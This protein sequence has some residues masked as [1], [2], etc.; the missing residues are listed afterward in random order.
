M[1]YK[2]KVGGQRGDPHKDK[3]LAANVAVNIQLVLGGEGNLGGD[4][5]DGGDD[6]GDGEDEAS[7]EADE[8]RAQ[9]EPAR[10]EDQRG[11]EQQDAVE[12]GAGHE[13]G[14]HD[15]RADAQ[16]RQ[17]GDDLGGQGDAGA[18]Q[19]LAD[20]DLDGVEPEEG[21]RRGA[22]RDASI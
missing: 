19:E 10:L 17:D 9:A 2:G 15:L 6:G 13:E 8:G 5:D 14:V 22:E 3:H 1:Q 11:Q 20:E 12:D 4:A 16:Q 18:G 21:F 7:D